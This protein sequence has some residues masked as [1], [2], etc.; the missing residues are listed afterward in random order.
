M[1][2]RDPTNP[3]PPDRSTTPRGDATRDALLRA[4]TELFGDQGYHAT[5]SR[6]LARAAG[7]NQA[8]IGYHFGGKKGLYLAVFDSIAD[9]MSERL[10]SPGAALR[11][12]LEATEDAPPDSER[13]ISGLLAVLDRAVDL[14]TSPD[15]EQWSKL[16]I[17]EQQSP[18][19]AFDRVW[20]RV[21]SPLAGVLCRLVG[22]LWTLPPDS[23]PVR[24]T[25]LTLLSQ[26]L[27]FRVA[28]ETAR[29]LLD[30][31][32]IG[33]TERSAIRHRIHQNVRSIL[34]Q[35]PLPQEP[36]S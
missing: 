9:A 24:L 27:I 29:R 35:R 19:S 31:D 15:T 18:S 4:G 26:P 10:G 21:M 16:I 1:E 23:T 36:L 14:F 2:R 20:S 34:A 5:S 12:Q 32:E 17:R 25:V 6:A 7:V 8:L 33:T 3:T 22:R 28:H 11:E 30:W 13:L